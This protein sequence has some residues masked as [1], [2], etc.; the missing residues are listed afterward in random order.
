M[1]RIVV[2]LAVLVMALM[3]V[4]YA[5]AQE[6]DA[7][8]DDEVAQGRPG[9]RG[10]E[11]RQDSGL[12]D[13]VAEALGIE[14]SALRDALEAAG[15]DATLNDVITELGG[16]PAEIQAAIIAE[17]EANQAERFAQAT[18]RVETFFS[19]SPAERRDAAFDFDFGFGFRDG[20]RDGRGPRGNRGFGGPDAPAGDDA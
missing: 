7:P 19:T 14:P 9:F 15:E 2:L 20:D 12:I 3:S 18:E 5:A 13:S 1:K 17:M 4:N 11:G 8:A 6:G 16:D 10:P